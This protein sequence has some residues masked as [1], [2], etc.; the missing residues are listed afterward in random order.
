MNLKQIKPTKATIP[1][2]IYLTSN[3]NREPERIIR[4]LTSRNKL[5]SGS[6]I[7]KAEKIILNEFSKG[8]YLIFTKANKGEATVIL[9][10]EN[11]IKK[12]NKELM[13]I[14]IRDHNPTQEHKKI[15]NHRIEIFQ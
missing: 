15:T 4:K 3:Q 5:F 12:A 6:N 13:R 10:V 8:D 7:S 11:Y 9:D 1:R 14:I 2:Q